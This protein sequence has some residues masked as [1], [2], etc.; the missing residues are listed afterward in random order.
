MTM[1]ENTARK[2]AVD[3]FITYG[4]QPVPK[5]YGSALVAAARGDPRIVCLTADL[6][7]HT[8]V[9]LFRDSLPDRFFQVGI[10]E[11]N[12]IGIAGGMARMG[13]IPFAHSFCSFATKRCFDQV[14][15]QV[16]YPRLPVKIVGFLPGVTTL[17]GVSHQAIEDLALMRAV[18]NMAILEP[19]GPECF[20]SAVA[21]CLDYDG[22]VYLRIKRP[23][24]PFPEDIP[25]EQIAIG[26]ARVLR[27]GDTA[28]IFASGM[29]VH[30][31]LIAADLLADQGAD[32]SVVDSGSIKPL[33][34]EKLLDIAARVR[35]VVT[36]ENHSIIGGLGSAVA[37]L[38]MEAGIHVAFSRV[39]LA[40][41]FAEGGSTPFLLGKYNLDARAIFNR[42]MQVLEKSA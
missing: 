40:D 16:A 30:E 20:A 37:E 10:A 33:D 39:G 8:E 17:L 14:T 13:D 2:A 27:Y 31:A 26:S 22:P 1:T 5:L 42:V 3:D 12:M 9:D 6:T 32:V 11:A 4:A 7:A 34:A 18:P 38:L 25:A 41:C 24:K 19:A 21:A 29:I 23:E 28:A 36:A 15:M 35:C